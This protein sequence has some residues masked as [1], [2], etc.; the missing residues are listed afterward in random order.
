MGENDLKDHLSELF[1]EVVPEPGLEAEP[2]KAEETEQ[3]LLED[4]V[5]FGLLG[6]ESVPAPIAAERMVADVSLP[7][8]L[9]AEESREERETMPAKRRATIVRVLLYALIVLGGVPILFFLVNL[10]WQGPVSWTPLCLVFYT[11]AVAV[12]LAQWMFNSSLTKTLQEAEGK[13]DEAIRSRAF[14]ENR[15]TGLSAANASLQ[16]RALQ[17]R[18]A[19][20]VSRAVA[21]TLEQDRLVEEAVNLIR[22]RFD[23]YHVGL[24][25]IDEPGEW[26]VLRAGTGEAGRQMLAQGRRFEVGGGSLA[27]RCMAGASPRIALDHAVMQ[28]RASAGVG[29]GIVAGDAVDTIEANS[30]LPETRSEMVLPLLAGGRA[31]GVLDVHSSMR[32]AFSAE[33]I[34]VFQ[35]MADQLAVALE[36]ARVFAETRSRLDV[37]EQGLAREQQARL[38]PVRPIPLYERTQPDVAPLG[39]DLLSEVE[40]AMAQREVLV[41]S[42]AGDGLGQVSSSS[43]Q[44][45]LVAPIELRG[46]IIGALGLQEMESGR[47]WTEDEIA[48][49]DA[50]VDQMALAIENARLLE[51]TRR[52]AEREQALS[53]MTARFTR[54]LNVDSLLRTAVREL[55]RLPNV[56]EVSV[57][58][59]PPP[60]DG[61]DEE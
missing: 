7:V 36:N 52:R 46:E 20:E 51:E 22:D 9:Q 59:S 11:L 12:T 58:V 33:D 54:S 23:L 41:L 14:L 15:V 30:L 35:A 49:I 53:D 4:M 24:F 60:A 32:E 44:A 8:P 61:G 10:L 16:R 28:S 19:T 31:I 43:G 17:L 29:D 50:V 2:E 48:L 57:H 42:D 39:D 5:L 37:L 18:A 25:L 55:G 1:S 3:F 45:A 6:D 27:G 13:R 26:V 40:R 21:A 38:S 47:R 56:A 34:P